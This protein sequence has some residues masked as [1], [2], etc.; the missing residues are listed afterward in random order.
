MPQWDADKLF[1]PQNYDVLETF[2]FTFGE[3]EK[4]WRMDTFNCFDNMSLFTGTPNIQFFNSTVSPSIME[5][6]PSV[7]VKRD[8]SSKPPR[9]MYALRGLLSVKYIIMPNW[10]ETNFSTESKLMGYEKAGEEY[11]YTTYRNTN[12]VPMG[13]AY[14]KYVTYDDLNSINSS[15]RSHVL[16]RAIAVEED[17]LEKYKI[18]IGRL[19][20]T[21]MYDYTYT[22]F[23]ED[24]A[25][26][27]RMSS[28]Y[29]EQT[30]DGFA[31]R[32]NLEQDN[33]VF[34]S[35]P[36]DEGF[37]AYVNGEESEVLKVNYA[38]C[39]VYAPAGE[40]EIVFEYSTPYLSTGIAVT[41]AGWAVYAVYAVLIKKKNTKEI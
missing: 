12:F 40:N 24:V 21:E 14:D 18:S 3:T 9:A 25:G 32:I 16:M 41:L 26:R 10:E 2:D 31:C 19:M 7:G 38:M 22:T 29:F 27:R 5:F 33:L 13:F 20:N 35:V 4:N 8:V 11:P 37:T 23:L 17:V 36:Y 30:D 34:F 1:R 6:Y 39:G 28:H 15:N